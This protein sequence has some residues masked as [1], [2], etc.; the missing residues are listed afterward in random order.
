LVLYQFKAG[1]AEEAL[2]DVVEDEPWLGV[3]AFFAATVGRF[4]VC[5]A[6]L[7]HYPLPLFDYRF[8]GEQA[9]HNRR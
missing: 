3:P 4:D 5:V 2:T 7:I 9:F 1:F 8:N 6:G